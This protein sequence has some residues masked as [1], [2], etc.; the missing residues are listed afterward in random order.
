LRLHDQHVNHRS[1]Q[2]PCIRSVG[3]AIVKILGCL[4][5]DRKNKKMRI[6]NAIHH[7]VDPLRSP[8]LGDYTN[9]KQQ[10]R[11][12]KDTFLSQFTEPSLALR[13]RNRAQLLA[14]MRISYSMS[15]LL[16]VR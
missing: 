8:H 1:G 4:T 15:T 7:S 16:G 5:P 13:A 2:I 11:G 12:L 10:L 6:Q 9:H 3:M 14:G